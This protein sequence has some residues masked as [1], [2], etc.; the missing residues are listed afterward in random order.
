MKFPPVGKRGFGLGPPQ[1]DYR[2]QSFAET[3]ADANACTLTVVQ[4]ESVKALERAE[5]LLAVPGV[6]VGLIGPSDLS[7][8][9]GV[10]GEFE[11]PRL[12][13]MICS[14]IRCVTAKAW[15]LDSGATQRQGLGQR[16]M[17]F[18]GCGTS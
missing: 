13:E 16:S 3:I 11:H 6:D 18:V 2:T 1:L 14:F 12:V 8:S 4:F 15:L 10:P 5:G 7:I 9:L 17:Q